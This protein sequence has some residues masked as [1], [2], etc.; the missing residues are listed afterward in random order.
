MKYIRGTRNLPLILSTNKSVILK[1]C[2]D[3]S[4]TVH[5]NMRGHAGGGISMG[6]GF[7]I[8]SPA[9][10]NLNTQISTGTENLAMGECM[11]AILC[12]RYWWDA[13]GYDISEEIVYQGN[14]SDILLE[15]NGKA[16]SRNLTKHI[17]TR[18]YF[19]TDRIEKYEPPLEWCPI[20]NIDW[21]F[22]DKT[23]SRCRV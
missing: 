16:S 8:V 9:K 14:K 18:Y 11:N 6:T 5:P 10:Q 15:N 13:E 23:N 19:V 3:R 4:F 21:I 20:A 17:N 12:T 22:H 2:I 1:W 7:P